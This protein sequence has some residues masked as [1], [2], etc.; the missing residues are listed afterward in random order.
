MIRRRKPFIYT[1]GL[2]SLLLMLPVSL[3]WLNRHH[4]FLRQ[5]TMEVVWYDSATFMEQQKSFK[6]RYHIDLVRAQRKYTMLTMNGLPKNDSTNLRLVRSGIQQMVEKGDTIK[7][8]RVHFLPDANF[9][10]FVAVND[11]CYQTKEITFLILES[12]IWIYLHSY[13]LHVPSRQFV[14]GTYLMEK[15]R[16]KNDAHVRMIQWN[17]SIEWKLWPVYLMFLL[18]ASYSL[19]PINFLKLRGTDK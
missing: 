18:L 14:C 7:G 17:N 12:D 13:A 19:S 1:P 5:R 8:I 6:E 2:L 9:E 15:D 3:M 4:Y 10:S 11:L 16:A